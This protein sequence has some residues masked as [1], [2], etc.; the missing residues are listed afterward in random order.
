[1]RFRKL[2]AWVLALAMVLSVAAPLD[3]APVLGDANGDDRV[4]VQDLQ[5]IVAKVLEGGAPDDRA[6]VNRDGAVNILDFQFVLAKVSVSDPE[7][8]PEPPRATP[9]EATLNHSGFE[10]ARLDRPGVSI[11]ARDERDASAPCRR[12]L[13]RAVALPSETERRFFTLTPHAPPHAHAAG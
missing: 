8:K 10:L 3:D 13:G 7:D 2:T 6:D 12:A 1:M 11:K 4:N 5:A 9:P